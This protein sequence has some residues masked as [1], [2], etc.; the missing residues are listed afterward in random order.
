MGCPRKYPSELLDRGAGVVIE[1]GRP[2][3]QVARDLGVPPGTLRRYVRQL[4]ADDGLR[5]DLPT[6]EERKEI[7]RLRVGVDPAEPGRGHE[8]RD[9]TVVG[10]LAL[11]L[12]RELG[13]PQLELVDQLQTGVD[14]AAPPIGDGQAVEQL[15][16]RVSD[17]LCVRPRRLGSCV[18]RAVGLRSGS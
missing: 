10:T 2:I 12:D 7:K 6:S 9:V 13:D 17:L 16:P 14:V 1:S 11:E 8:Q 3:A 4:E 15:A 18:S 5:P